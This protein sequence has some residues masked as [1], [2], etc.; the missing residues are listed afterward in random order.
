VSEVWEGLSLGVV[1]EKLTTARFTPSHPEYNYGNSQCRP[2]A[3]EEKC[4]L[5][6]TAFSA[7]LRI[8]RT[9]FSMHGLD[10]CQFPGCT[11][12]TCIYR[13]ARETDSVVRMVP[14][15]TGVL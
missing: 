7:S 8:P 3:L 15:N 5:P 2:K 13:E 6:K 10:K 12:D 9:L 4:P 1:G 14:E 11:G